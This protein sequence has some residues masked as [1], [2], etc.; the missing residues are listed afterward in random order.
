MHLKNGKLIT[1]KCWIQLYVTILT[2]DCQPPRRR[3]PVASTSKQPAKGRRSKLAQENE[4]SAQDEV[5]IKDAWEMFAVHD[6]E[7]FRDEKEG[8][9]R[10]EDVRRAMKY[11][12]LPLGRSFIYL[13]VEFVVG[14]R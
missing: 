14:C 4:I 2:T 12:N 13:L 10:T 6:I 3:P 9:M 1:Q 11:V 8:V 5:E 7:E